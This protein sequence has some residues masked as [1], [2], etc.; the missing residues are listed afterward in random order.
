M[1]VEDVGLCLETGVH[2]GL[3][4]GTQSLG[5]SG[6][7]VHRFGVQGLRSTGVKFAVWGIGN[8][9]SVKTA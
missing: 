4:K 9:F 1:R 2:L 5:C 7:R 8:G 6:L 3:F